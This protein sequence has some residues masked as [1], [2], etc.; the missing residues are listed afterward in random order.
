MFPA[1]CL[2][3]VLQTEPWKISDDLHTLASSIF[4]ATRIPDFDREGSC[5]VQIMPEDS[6]IAG[7]SNEPSALRAIST[8]LTLE[9][10]VSGSLESSAAQL[11]FVVG[12][13]LE[14]VEIAESA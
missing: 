8:V 4:T 1:D 11:A 5:T 10:L 6:A 12:F 2:V 3:D 13:I 14:G 7:C 9:W